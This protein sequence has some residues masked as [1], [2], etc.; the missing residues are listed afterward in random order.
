MD[1]QSQKERI[2]YEVIVDCYDE[3]EMSMGWFYYLY[4][5]LTFPFKAIFLYDSEIGDFKKGDIILVNSD[6]DNISI[7]DFVATVEV[8]KDE[9]IYEIPLMM[10]QGVD[11]SEATNQVIEDWRYWCKEY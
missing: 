4:D 5:N 7:Y 10:L 8:S 1:Y 9:D 2:D 3:Y 6:K 11:C